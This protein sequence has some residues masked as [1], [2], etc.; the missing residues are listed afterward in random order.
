MRTSESD[1]KL[2]TTAFTHYVVFDVYACFTFFLRCDLV[3]AILHI[4]KTTKRQEDRA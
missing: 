4:I 1:L 3:R 2:P